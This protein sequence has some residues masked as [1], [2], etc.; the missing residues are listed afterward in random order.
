MR[1]WR[2]LQHGRQRGKRVVRRQGIRCVRV[3]STRQLGGVQRAARPGAPP[4]R[5]AC[6]VVCARVQGAPN[7][8]GGG[9]GWCG[10]VRSERAVDR[11]RQGEAY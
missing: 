4:A 2:A 10:A 3:K 9:R 5:Q 6:G 11:C 7:H 1:R 8:A